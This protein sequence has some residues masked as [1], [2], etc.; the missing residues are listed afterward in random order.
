M[1]SA[2]LRYIIVICTAL[3]IELAC[4]TGLVSP[5]V[6]T[7]PSTAFLKMLEVLIAGRYSR[8]IADTFQ[9]WVIAVTMAMIVGVSIGA[10]LHG[11][12]WRRTLDPFITTLNGV[13]VYVFY[14]LFVLLFGLGLWSKT[15]I[16]FLCALMVVVVNTLLGLDRVPP[17][18]LRVAQVYR[19]SLLRTLLEVRLRYAVP[20][21]FTSFRL[22]VAWAFVG[23]IGAEFIASA[24]G[25]GHEIAFTY[26]NFENDVMYALILFVLLF[27]LGVNLVLSSVERQLYAR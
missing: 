24:H 25:L 21:I 15:L 2:K 7:S 18:L 1:T 12:P 22:A 20:W 19:F 23:I 10:F 17:V 27:A 11:K 14:P 6:F 3:F 16:G 5:H 13:P 9:S 8:D 26:N 4:R